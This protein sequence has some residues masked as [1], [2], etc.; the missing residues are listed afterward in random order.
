LS[1][2]QGFRTTQALNQIQDSVRVGFEL[3]ARDIRQAANLPCGTDVPVVNILE[4]A[5]QGNTPWQYDWD[6]G[7][8]GL[9]ANSSLTGVSNRVAGTEALI[10]MSADAGNVYMDQYSHSNN[11]ANFTVGYS[12][13]SH[14]L[15]NGDILMVCNEKQ[16]TIFQMSRGQ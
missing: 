6:A 14:G 16:A 5:T 4:P 1:N 3:L 10:L 9:T 2:N 7:I 15:R 11:G 8:E 12:G 13:Q